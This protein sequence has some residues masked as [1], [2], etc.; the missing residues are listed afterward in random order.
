[1]GGFNSPS[2]WAFCG[3]AWQAGRWYSLWQDVLL[4]QGLAWQNGRS[5]WASGLDGRGHSQHTCRH[6]IEL[7]YCNYEFNKSVAPCRDT[8]P[9]GGEE[10]YCAF[11]H[12]IPLC[13][14]CERDVS[15]IRTNKT[16]RQMIDSICEMGAGETT[17]LVTTPLENCIIAFLY[18][19]CCVR[20]Y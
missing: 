20:Q 13:L 7:W 6:Y 17:S 9:S 1:M 2:H 10:H 14:H 5:V 18:S 3:A 19:W 4:T 15:N 11:E 16:D 12:F 8:R